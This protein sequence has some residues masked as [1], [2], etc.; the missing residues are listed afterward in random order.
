MITDELN[1][2]GFEIMNEGI[3]ASWSNEE[4]V[5]ECYEFGR[6]IGNEIK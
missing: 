6:N 1:K 4:A 5:E 3:R 2:A